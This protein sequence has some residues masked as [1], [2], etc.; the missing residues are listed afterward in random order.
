MKIGILTQPLHTN[1]GG[2]LQAF[3]LQRFLRG[4][5]HDA[6]TIDYARRERPW[7]APYRFARRCVGKFLLGRGGAFFPK[8]LAAGT[9]RHTARF[10]AENIRTTQKIFAPA[11]ARDFA[12]YAFDAF[13]VGSDQTWRPAYSPHMP[14]F[15]LDFLPAEDFRTRRVAYAA[16]F[17][18]ETWEFSPQLTRV[19]APLAKRFHAISVREDSGVA[20]CEKFF[21]VPAEHLPDPTL[22]L[23]AEVYREIVERDEARGFLEKRVPARRV[24]A[25]ILDASAEKSAAVARA[26][27]TL[28]AEAEEIMPSMA[29]LRAGTAAF[30]PVSAWLRGFRD[31]EFVVTDSF[32]GCVFSLIFGRPFLALGNAARGMARFSSLL[33]LFG[34]ERRLVSPKTLAALPQDA[35]AALLAERLDCARIS[36]VLARERAR[37]REFLEKALGV[38][39]G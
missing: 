31:A 10:V 32:H 13:V 18:T 24:F 26:A 8:P 19:C 3:A 17:G 5:G 6:L 22:L 15:F 11:R 35:F 21:G 29:A 16:S 39:R 2:L 7:L 20:L 36:A 25:Y 14:T 12:E 28:G 38:E 37:S 33:N 4:M 30:P 9:G 27:E 1:Y 34:A 23:D